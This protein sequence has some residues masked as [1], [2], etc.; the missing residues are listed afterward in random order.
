MRF[1]ATVEFLSPY[2]LFSPEI[3]IQYLC[4]IISSY[5]VFTTV[6]FRST[7]T[8]TRFS[9]GFNNWI[10]DETNSA[11]LEYFFSIT[12]QLLQP[13]QSLPCSTGRCPSSAGACAPPPLSPWNSQ[14]EES[15]EDK[16]RSRQH[17]HK[18]Q[19]FSQ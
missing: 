9:L 2:T 5:T 7:G 16:P 14:A 11:P 18:T 3:P 19:L 8:R 13:H 17:R 6:I 15:W 4:F 1:K 12:E 10:P